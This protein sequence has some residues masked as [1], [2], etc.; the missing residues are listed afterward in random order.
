M[1]WGRVLKK[2]A[3]TLYPINASIITFSMG[4]VIYNE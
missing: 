1:G 3:P 2:W 4:T